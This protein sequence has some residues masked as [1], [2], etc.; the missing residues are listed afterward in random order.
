MLVNNAGILKVSPLAGLLTR[1]FS[2]RSRSISP[3]RS[4]ACARARIACATE[5]AAST[6]RPARARKG[7]R[8]P[9]RHRL[10]RKVTSS[11]SRR[12][13]FEQLRHVGQRYPRASSAILYRSREFPVAMCS[14]SVAARKAAQ[15]RRRRHIIGSGPA[16]LFDLDKRGR[17]AAELL[18]RVDEVHSRAGPGIHAGRDAAR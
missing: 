15:R 18:R 6:S 8:H 1:T 13:F 4:T 10:L 14:M 17:A 5:A 7:T 9:R 3:G 16:E 2:A 11:R 12:L